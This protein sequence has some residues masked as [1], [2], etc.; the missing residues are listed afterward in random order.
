MIVAI[1]FAGTMPLVMKPTALP[2]IAP[3]GELAALR[4]CPANLFFPPTP[5]TT[6][7]PPSDAVVR[8]GM[9]GKALAERG[10]LAVPFAAD[11][12]NVTVHE[13]RR[14]GR[15]R[16]SHRRQIREPPTH[17]K[18]D[19]TRAVRA[20]PSKRPPAD[21]RRAAHRRLPA[22]LALHIHKPERSPH[23]PDMKRIPPPRRV[24][25]RLAPK[26]PSQSL[27]ASNSKG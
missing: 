1:P 19:N 2:T 16:G 11:S 15:R 27:Q 17:D 13:S 4:F 22:L 18:P 14:N 9:L 20:Q 23:N 3:S 25:R 7:V 26:L 12:R 6:S 5:A 24:R 21:T 8:S 10:R